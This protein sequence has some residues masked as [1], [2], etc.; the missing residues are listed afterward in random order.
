M[1]FFDFQTSSV[2]SSTHNCLRA[3]SDNHTIINVFA[4]FI[5]CSSLVKFC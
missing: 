3:G 1:E 4:I 5:A 2:V